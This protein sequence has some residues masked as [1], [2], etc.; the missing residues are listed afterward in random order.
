MRS[1]ARRLLRPILARLVTISRISWQ[2]TSPAF[3]RTMVGNTL[4][5]IIHWS[6]L[7]SCTR[8]QNVAT[9]FARNRKEAEW[10]AREAS[11]LAA[12]GPLRVA[13]IACSSGAEAYSLAWTIR[14]RE[15]DLPIEITGFDVSETQLEQARR[16]VYEGTRMEFHLLTGDEIVRHFDSLG[17]GFRVR[18]IPGVSF[19]WRRRDVCAP[20]EPDLVGAFD[21]VTANRFLC[22]MEPEE[23][24]RCLGNTLRIVRPGGVVSVSG[25]DCRV[26]EVVSLAHEL[27]PVRDEDIEPVY[28]GDPTLTVGWPFKY[29]A[30][31]PVDRTRKNWRFRYSP[32]L[33]VPDRHGRE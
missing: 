31:E 20:W 21:V 14:E 19:I 29:Y 28:L 5:R 23:A 15:T 32:L 25:I 3:R 10:I 9:C 33:I 6:L 8:T 2:K 4:G 1:T 30:V 7:M 13:V 16:G 17:H 11:R 24:V 27:V 12:D 22:H 18:S 26:R